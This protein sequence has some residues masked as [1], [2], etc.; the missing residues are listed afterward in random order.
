M[1]PTTAPRCE[2]P[3]GMRDQDGWHWVQQGEFAPTLARWHPAG[4]ADVGPLWTSIEHVYSAA[5]AYAVRE[6]GW[7]YIAPVASAAEVEALQAER[8]A[9]L[10]DSRAAIK[11]HA[12]R[13]AEMVRLQE[14]VAELETYGRAFVAWTKANEFTDPE[15][16][17]V[18]AEWHNL[19]A[20]VERKP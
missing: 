12:Q 13:A 7:R 15:S 9:L 8:D 10:A 2:P 17:L 20:T 3:E 11:A 5:P 19:C 6:W 14:R 18:C 4:R 16:M 1:T